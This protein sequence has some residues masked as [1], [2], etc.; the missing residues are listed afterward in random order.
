MYLSAIYVRQTMSVSQIT[1]VTANAVTTTPGQCWLGLYN[2]SGTLL[3]SVDTSGTIGAQGVH[4]YALTSQTLAPGFYYVG[5][6]STS[7]PALQLMSGI[8]VGAT[9]PIMNGNLTNPSR[10]RFAVN[11]TGQT[12]LPSTL[13]LASNSATGSGAFW[14]ALN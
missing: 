5:F 6:L 3:A 7:S 11:G 12:T 9:K 8:T 13:T 10:L 14:V 1:V 2:S 4:Q